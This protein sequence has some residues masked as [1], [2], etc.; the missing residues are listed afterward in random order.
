[1]GM[2]EINFMLEIDFS[3]NSLQKKLGVLRGAFSGFQI[4]MESLHSI[5]QDVTKSE[6]RLCLHTCR[7]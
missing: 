3:R 4:N 1:M 7:E 6:C 5:F 2:E